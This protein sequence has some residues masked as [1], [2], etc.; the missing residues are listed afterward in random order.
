[1]K[2]MNHSRNNTLDFM[3][4][5]A[6]Y[7]VVFIHVLFYG[8]VG[9]L[10]DALA[11]F[12]VPL[13]FTVSGFYSYDVTEKQIKRR[14][15]HIFRLLLLAVAAYTLWNVL[16]YVIAWDIQGLVQ[17]FSGYSNLE[18]LAKLFLLNV[19]LC[20]V[21][22]WYLYAILYVYICYLFVLVFKI[23]KKIV[24]LVSLLLLVIHILL[25]EGLAICKV[26]V[27]ITLVRNFALMGIPFF[28]LGLLANRYRYKLCN[29]SN[30][31]IIISLLIGMVETAL[32]RYFF[33]KNEL[34]IGS[35]FVLFSLVVIFVKYP[36]M[37]LPP[38]LI[39]IASCSTYIYIFHPMVSVV[40]EMIYS[41]C[42]FNYYSSVFLQ[43][44]HPIVVCMLSSLLALV[45][46]KIAHNIQI[47]RAS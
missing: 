45:I 18:R 40:V 25:G 36:H 9:T 33:G 42:S 11:R 23:N 38:A 7:M 14:I 27:P 12:A 24:F 21:H 15:V 8:Q 19:S 37:A 41:I 32:S 22:L 20:S 1:M 39:L 10:F 31:I 35:V 5:I 4:L 47:S 2:Q 34:Y 44:L 13:F 43:M 16:L 30:G 3:K 29:I 26:I 28:G 6:S 17:Y 46:N